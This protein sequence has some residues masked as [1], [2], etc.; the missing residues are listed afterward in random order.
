MRLSRVEVHRTTKF[1]G[2][3]DVITGIH[4]QT[5]RTVPN[6]RTAAKPHR[7]LENTIGVQLHQKRV[8]ATSAGQDINVAWMSCRGI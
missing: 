7:P 3:V 1:S 5:T 8:V 4:G 2:N 6:A